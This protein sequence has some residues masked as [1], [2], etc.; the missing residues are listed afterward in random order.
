MHVEFI[1]ILR[2]RPVVTLAHDLM[3]CLTCCRMAQLKLSDLTLKNYQWAN[4]AFRPQYFYFVLKLDREN[5][6][7]LF[8][9][10]CV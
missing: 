1:S 2:N 4:L 6:A 9:S 5:F 3:R 7:M 8:A 10:P